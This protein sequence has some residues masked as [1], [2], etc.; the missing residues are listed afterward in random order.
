M[1]GH[2]EVGASTHPS[3]AEKASMIIDGPE[4]RVSRGCGANFLEIGSTE[5]VSISAVEKVAT[6]KTCPQLARVRQIRQEILNG[7]TTGESI[8]LPPYPSNALRCNDLRHTFSTEKMQPG[9]QF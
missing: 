5:I 4:N 7:E 3:T 8:A 2:V 9:S 1:R 6:G